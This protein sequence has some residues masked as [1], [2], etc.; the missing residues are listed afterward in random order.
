MDERAS[1]QSAIDPEEIRAGIKTWMDIETPSHEGEE[2][3]KFV[4]LVKKYI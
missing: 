4:D 3:N 2:V 1:N